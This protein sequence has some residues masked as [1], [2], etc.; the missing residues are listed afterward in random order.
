MERVGEVAYEL[1][2]L[3]DSKVHN[4]FHVSCF[5]KAL[6]HRVVPSVTLPPLDDE[7]K[8]IFVPK[9]NLDVRER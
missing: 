1:E 2:F 5:Q 6:G 3:V 8:L 9:A 7:G 4:D